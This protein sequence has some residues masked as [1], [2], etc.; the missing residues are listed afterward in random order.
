M[1]HKDDNKN[2]TN[3]LELRVQL[4]LQPTEGLLTIAPILRVPDFHHP[5]IVEVGASLEVP[6]GSPLPG[7]GIRVRSS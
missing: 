7:A 6:G 2:T 3:Q 5:C 1:G 4:C